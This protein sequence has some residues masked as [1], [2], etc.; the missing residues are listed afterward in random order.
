[1]LT[2]CKQILYII[3]PHILNLTHNIF[4]ISGPLKCKISHA[5]N[6]KISFQY[7]AALYLETYVEYVLVTY[8]KIILKEILYKSA[9]KM[10]NNISISEQ[11][12]S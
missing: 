10:L 8:C 3:H 2:Y 11:H 9:H 1:M 5:Q 4:S 12:I 6:V 7:D